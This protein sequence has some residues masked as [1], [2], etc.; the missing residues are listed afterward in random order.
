M[1]SELLIPVM[2]TDLPGTVM[3]T[4]SCLEEQ[5]ASAILCLWRGVQ[6]WKTCMKTNVWS[7]RSEGFCAMCRKMYVFMHMVII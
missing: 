3:K 4:C 1:E 2:L 7:S 6:S 5:E